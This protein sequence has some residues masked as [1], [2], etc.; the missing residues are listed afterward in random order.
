MD[1]D[2]LADRVIKPELKLNGRVWKGRHAS[3]AAILVAAT[4]AVGVHL[5][6]VFYEEP[7]LRKKF[8]PEYRRVLP[9]R[10]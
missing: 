9:K 6:V 5:F 2:N 1:L 3:P 7:V 10:V 4:V 8:G